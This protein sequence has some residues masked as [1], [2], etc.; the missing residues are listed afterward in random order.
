MVKGVTDMKK[1]AKILIIIG[2]ILGFWTVLPL[3]FGILA[4]K[5]MKEG[6]PSTG[7]CVCVL[8]FCSTLGGIFLLCS[9]EEEYV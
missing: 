5:K 2:M 6:K 7:F 3:I 1:A 8:L 9:K 4:L